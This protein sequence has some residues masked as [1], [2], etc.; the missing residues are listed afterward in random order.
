MRLVLDTNTL[1]SGLLWQGTPGKLIDAAYNDQVTLYTSVPLLGELQ[2]V[3]YRKKFSHQLNKRGLA[4]EDF[5][6]GYTTLAS[7]VIPAKIDP[8]VVRDPDDDHV[9]ACALA[10]QADLIVSG[11]SDLLTLKEYQGIPIVDAVTALKQIKQH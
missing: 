2:G 10:A 9:I 1:I 8:V 11:D 3:L 4:A 5:F 7:M 6:E